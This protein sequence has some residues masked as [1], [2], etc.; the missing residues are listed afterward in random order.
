MGIINAVKGGFDLL[1]KE[2]RFPSYSEI[3]YRVGIKRESMP[4]PAH[5]QI[6]PTTRCNLNCITCSRKSLSTS[7]FN[8]T[9]SL[10]E[11]KHIIDQIPSLKSVQLSGLGEPLLTRD[12]EH[13]AKYTKEKNIKLST[14][15]NG[16]LIN[17]K[18][19]D[20]LLNFFDQ[21]NISIDSA[22]ADSYN[23]IRSG[24]DFTKLIENINMITRKKATSNSKTKL[25]L[26]FTVT[27]K[28]YRELTEYLALCRQLH[29]NCAVVEVENWY[30][31]SQDKYK[32][33]FEFIENSRSVSNDIKT[34][35]LN[36][37]QGFKRDGLQLL[38]LSPEKRKGI[39]SWAFNQC[40]ITC[41]GYITP[42][43]IRMD[44]DIFNFGNIYESSFKELWDSQ[45]FRKFRKTMIKNLPN[46]VC[47]KCPD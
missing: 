44:P 11:Y 22:K 15:T 46:P 20:T 35:V 39:C 8:K 31:P 4:L 45:K 27:H 7:R 26:T 41:D 38:Y 25:F 43:C 42:C 28:N 24:G 47:D 6:E 32:E 2:K 19:A 17:E 13:I 29:V 10:D 33:M 18:N 21:I 36:S 12:L 30:V 14:N 34:L 9:L 5:I 40:F 23:T 3:V 37:K 16:S 1:L